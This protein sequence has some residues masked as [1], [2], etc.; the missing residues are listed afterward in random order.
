MFPLK[1]SIIVVTLGILFTP[2]IAKANVFFAYI[3]RFCT[4]VYPFYQWF[5]KKG[6]NWTT[7]SEK[8]A[9][10]SLYFLIWL[11]AVIGLWLHGM[12][13]KEKDHKPDFI[14]TWNIES[15][16]QKEVEKEEYTKDSSWPTK[17]QPVSEQDN[18][19]QTPSANA[20]KYAFH[21]VVD[22]DTIKIK[23]KQNNLYSV[24]MIWLDA[25]ESTTMRYGY[26]E[27]FGKEAANHLKKLIGSEKYIH[28]EEDHTQTATDKYGRLLGYVIVNWV[29]LNQKMIEDWYGFEY[30]YN[31]PYKYQS[32][33]K[34]AQKT[35][36]EKRLW[37]WDD[38][39]C[40]GERKA[41]ESQKSIP[42]KQIVAPQ[43]QS[44][45]SQKIYH[46]WKRGGCYY[47]NDQW[48]KEYVNHSFCK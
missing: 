8:I 10:F 16:I 11:L 33:F 3:F 19:Y 13:T 22:W 39:A 23:D 25:P 7:T 9:K 44:T 26:A 46:T 36:S 48:K 15:N 6:K 1:T 12:G 18:Q 2:F 41:L 38:S 40:N 42:V 37:L 21:S 45:S 24:R 20:E 30:T 35:A 28:L 34:S 43:K 27:C 5:Y 17:Q 14:A 32:E 29:N 31:F 47:Y 4:L